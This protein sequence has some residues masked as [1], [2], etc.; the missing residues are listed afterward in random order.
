MIFGASKVDITKDSRS[1]CWLVCDSETGHLLVRLSFRFLFLWEDLLRSQ[2]AEQLVNCLEGALVCWGWPTKEELSNLEERF[3]GV[4]AKSPL[5]DPSKLDLLGE[6][7]IM[8]TL[9]DSPRKNT[10]SKG[11]KRRRKYV[12]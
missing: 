7:W 8:S 11:S 5:V 12:L 4:T 9:T 1:L 3:P 6:N 10:S 2:D